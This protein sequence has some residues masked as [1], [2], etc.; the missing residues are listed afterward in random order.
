MKKLDDIPK[1]NIFKVPEGYFEQLPTVIQSR[2]AK[3]GSRS[4]L[5]GI[6]GLW[7]KYALP[8][9]VLAIVA[10]LWLRPSPTVEMQLD[11]IDAGQIALYFDNTYSDLDQAVDENHEWTITELDELEDAVYSNMEN[12]TD[13]TEDILDDI[14]L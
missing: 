14:D 4:P 11:D 3:E 5:S 8:V 13:I 6:P 12:E 2:I 9:I 7:L 10:T 1:K